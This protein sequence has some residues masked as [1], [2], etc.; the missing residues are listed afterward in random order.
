[1]RSREEKN[2][3]GQET[4]ELLNEEFLD[5]TNF[6]SHCPLIQPVLSIKTMHKSEEIKLTSQIGPNL[7]ALIK[8][9]LQL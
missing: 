6:Q 8:T 2:R 1:M 3:F 7:Q 5:T 4:K 9:T